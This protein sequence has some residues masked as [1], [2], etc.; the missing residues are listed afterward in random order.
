MP[1]FNFKIINF[2]RAVLD[3]QKIDQEEQNSHIPLISA[4]FAVSPVTNNLNSCGTFVV[5][6]EQI[7]MHYYQLSLQ[8][9]ME[10]LLEIMESNH[11]DMKD[12]ESLVPLGLPHYPWSL[13]G[14]EM[15]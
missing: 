2:F 12:E 9:I 6:G 10:R 11:S 4:H 7:L 1:L 13:L 5:I 8:V 14:T 3:L 15:T